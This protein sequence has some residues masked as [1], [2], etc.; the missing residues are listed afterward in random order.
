V[1]IKQFGDRRTAR[2]DNFNEFIGHY[3]FK[4]VRVAIRDPESPNTLLNRSASQGEKDT[5]HQKDSSFAPATRV[6]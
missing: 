5:F 3:L 6:L 1:P 2:F 4:N